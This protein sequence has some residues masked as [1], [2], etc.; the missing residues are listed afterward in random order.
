[1]LFGIYFL[2]RRINKPSVKTLTKVYIYKCACVCVC[3]CVCVV[4]PLRTTYETP[5]TQ[6]KM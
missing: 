5:V 4:S 2:P 3:V 1:M 6:L